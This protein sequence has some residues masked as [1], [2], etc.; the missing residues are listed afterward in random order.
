[1]KKNIFNFLTILTLATTVFVACDEDPNGNGNNGNNGNSKNQITMVTAET[2][3]ELYLAGLGNITIDWGDGSEKEPFTLISSET[4]Y[5]HNYSSGGAHTIV[6]KGNVTSLEDGFK[7][8]YIGVSSLDVSNNSSLTFLKLS[9]CELTSLDLSKNTALK[10]LHLDCEKLTSLDLSKN[11][12]LE[13]LELYCRKL[14]SLDLTKN[15]AL[16]ELTLGCVELTCNVSN[17]PVLSELECYGINN[18]SVSNCPLLK[19][20]DSY[21]FSGNLKIIYCS[22]LESVFIGAGM[23]SLDVSNCTSL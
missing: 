11:T 20:A 7:E 21:Y 8:Y 15:L 9:S 14:T 2:K 12:A 22:S 17:L 6:I 5:K 19:T 18:L 4:L 1:M 16:K 23:I 10:K 3:V 13:E